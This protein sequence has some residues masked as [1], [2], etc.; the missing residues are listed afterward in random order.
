MGNNQSTSW[1]TPLRCILDNWKMFNPLTLRRRYLKFFCATA[2]PRYP[3]GDKENWP[4]DGPLNYDTILQLELF[5]K[6]QGKWT[7]IPYVQIFF[8]LRD[9]KELCLKYWIVVGPKSEP[10]RQMVLGTGNQEKEP[11][12]PNR[13]RLTSHSSRVAWCFFVLSKCAPISGSAPST[14][15]SS[16]M[17][18]SWNWRRIRTNPGP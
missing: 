10:T 16:S 3:L 17:S 15:A 12:P 7:E 5:C 9:M 13:W 1:Q 2:W 11:P 4:E 18:L 14:K 8:R 6:G